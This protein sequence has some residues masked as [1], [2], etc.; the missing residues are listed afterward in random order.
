MFVDSVLGNTPKPNLVIPCASEMWSCN[1]RLNV[2][3]CLETRSQNT[4]HLTLAGQLGVSRVLDKRRHRCLPSVAMCRHG[5]V[6]PKG[7]FAIWRGL[8]E[9]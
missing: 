5:Q 9:T 8:K 3:R 1:Q 7:A 4:L 2:S 6:L